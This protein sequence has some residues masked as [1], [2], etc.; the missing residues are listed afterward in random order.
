MTKDGLVQRITELEKEKR[1]VLESEPQFARKLAYWLTAGQNIADDF[2]DTNQWTAE[3][4]LAGYT[5]PWLGNKIS[6]ITHWRRS[7]DYSKYP[8][9][10]TAA[11]IANLDIKQSKYDNIKE[12]LYR[13]E[14]KTTAEYEKLCQNEKRTKHNIK[15][16]QEKYGHLLKMVEDRA[17]YVHLPNISDQN[18]KKAIIKARRLRTKTWKIHE[19]R[20]RFEKEY[21]E[22]YTLRKTCNELKQIDAKLKETKTQL[23]DYQ[24]EWAETHIGQYTDKQEA[25]KNARKAAETAVFNHDYISKK[26]LE[27]EVLHAIETSL[28]LSIEELKDYHERAISYEELVDQEGVEYIHAHAEEGF[29]Q[30]TLDYQVAEKQLQG[31]LRKTLTTLNSNQEKVL[32]MHYGIDEEKEYTLS[33]IGKKLGITG[34]RVREIE[35]DALTRLRNPSRTRVLKPYTNIGT[36]KKPYQISIL[37]K[38]S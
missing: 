20:Q 8:E 35:K 18:V 11:M 19:Q 13:L 5:F 26:S 14:D 3:E 6:K 28:D 21:G 12:S 9:S 27:G 15:Q 2:Y 22:T 4:D 37:P 30:A 38:T 23:S 36:D 29:E 1:H 25:V 16:H 31:Q 17:G 32:K 24:M 33:E 10:G 7:F 34:H